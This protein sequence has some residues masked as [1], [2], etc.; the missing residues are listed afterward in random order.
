MVLRGNGLP[1]MEMEITHTSE[2]IPREVLS[3]LRS[4]H[5]PRTLRNPKRDFSNGFIVAT[6]CSRYWS[7]VSMHS[8]EDKL[9]VS[10]KRSNWKELK[11]HFTLNK[12]PI[13]DRMIDGLIECRDGYAQSLVRQLY[14]TLTGRQ[15]I[16]AEPLPAEEVIP[17]SLAHMAV[18]KCL[19]IEANT[20]RLEE[21]KKRSDRIRE[22]RQRDHMAFRR[23]D[24]VDY[25]HVANEEKRGGLHPATNTKPGDANTDV[26]GSQV[27]QKLPVEFSVSMR[28]SEPQRTVVRNT[29][30]KPDDKG[31][32]H[33]SGREQDAQWLEV[34]HVFKEEL[35]AIGL[36]EYTVRT[37]ATGLKP[38]SARTGEVT[39]FATTAAEA[40]FTTCFLSDE[41]SIG[42]L[43]QRRLW[44]AILSSVSD[45][46]DR[47]LR[48]ATAF[49]EIA[50]L[51]LGSA[52]S[53]LGAQRQQ[54]E[55]CQSFQN[56]T[57]SS[58]M[59]KPVRPLTAMGGN[60][61]T[62]RFFFIAS[63]LSSISDVDPFL[64]LSMYCDDVL[65]HARAQMKQLNH[66]TAD[67]FASLLCAALPTNRAIATQAFQNILCA[68]HNTIKTSDSA[69]E[70]ASFSLFL[71]AVM[72][73]LRRSTVDSSSLNCPVG[74]EACL[75]KV[76]GCN[77]MLH[78][79][80]ADP[81]YCTAL[82]VAIHDVVAALVH[83]SATVRLVGAH[84]AKVLTSQG[85]ST[86]LLFSA[87]VPLMGSCCSGIGNTWAFD[88]VSVSWLRTV[89]RRIC[90]F[91]SDDSSSRHTTPTASLPSTSL[92][93]VK[94]LLCDAYSAIPKH[95][96]RILSNMT[97]YFCRV[98]E[99]PGP[100]NA[101]LYIAQQLALCIDLIPSFKNPRENFR[102]NELAVRVLTVLSQAPSDVVGTFFTP[103]SQ[104]GIALSE[105]NVR[106]QMGKLNPP[107]VCHP[108]TGPMY[109]DGCLG[110]CYPLQ[111]SEAVLLLFPVEP[112]DAPTSLTPPPSEVPKRISANLPSN[113]GSVNTSPPRCGESWH[114]SSRAVTL[115][116][117]GVIP[118]SLVQRITWLYQIN[119]SCRANAPFPG[120]PATMSEATSTERWGQLFQ[121]VYDD[122]AL[123]TTA[124]EM[125]AAQKGSAT[126]E[127]ETRIVQV[128]G[129]AQQ[130]VFRWYTE[131]SREATGSTRGW[132]SPAEQRRDMDAINTSR[133]CLGK[134]AEA[135]AWYYSVCGHDTEKEAFFP[136]GAS[137]YRPKGV[138]KSMRI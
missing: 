115:L 25:L 6:I 86:S 4:L 121:S 22:I 109:T 10:N 76:G 105:G 30:N 29:G 43:L 124:A 53:K 125:V 41:T 46:V 26:D 110:D 85:C 102:I 28:R 3:W 57:Q 68:V 21:S 40:V 90:Q 130:L 73:R 88:C 13:S 65:P 27:L 114:V 127:I 129:M 54:Q 64:A 14:T 123:V 69:S 78:E 82:S 49:N 120:R 45:V 32:P 119:V 39:V 101:R 38:P 35:S 111:L 47:I 70:R 16:E 117:D 8:Y 87:L 1:L 136:K 31:S 61:S 132:V 116:R 34:S 100:S 92:R 93:A 52:T 137:I 108:L 60:F 7:S 48:D 72:L 113:M 133:E 62:Q 51:F 23:M 122:I 89:W 83:E 15:I 135:M 106:G 94:S 79:C 77:E 2:E 66:V 12:C 84:F 50:A 126:E 5:L 98:L 103:P 11:K 36:I 134:I 18:D 37:Q 63:L 58:Q 138:S 91:E 75:E 104:P 97:G 17:P 19:N 96:L 44:S 131:L 95:I 80:A 55:K 71:Q 81:L 118:E 24:N 56:K 9:S 112:A 33:R 99:R 59:W 67:D 74:Q 107:L 42:T 20:D 128:A